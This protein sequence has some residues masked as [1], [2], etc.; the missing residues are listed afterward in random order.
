MLQKAKINVEAEFK[1][2]QPSE[3]QYEVLNL[4]IRKFYTDNTKIIAENLRVPLNGEEAKK[5]QL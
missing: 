5:S 3:K 4:N 2:F 1:N